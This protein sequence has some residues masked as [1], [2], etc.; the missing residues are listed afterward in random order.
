MTLAGR[1]QVFNKGLAAINESRNKAG[2]NDM[3][4]SGKRGRRNVKR[5]SQ[6]E[7]ERR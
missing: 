2:E 6:R 3:R 4:E 5:E 1:Y 7:L